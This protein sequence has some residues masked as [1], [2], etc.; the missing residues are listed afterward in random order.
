MD[1]ADLSL[2]DPPT[3]RDIGEQHIREIN[4]ANRILLPVSIGPYSDFGPIF[5]NFLFGQA[6]LHDLTSLRNRPQANLARKRATTH[7]A[8]IGIV[9]TASDNWKKNKSRTL[10]GH[11]YTA[12]TTP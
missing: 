10:F 8:P 3:S 11:S 2:Q 9:I 12:P 5:D 1:G 6:P 7:P 4:I